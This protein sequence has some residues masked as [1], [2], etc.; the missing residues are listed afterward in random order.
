MRRARPD[1]GNRP[2]YLSLALLTAAV[3]LFAAAVLTWLR[4]PSDE[5]AVYGVVPAAL[6]I[7]AWGLAQALASGAYD[8]PHRHTSRRRRLRHH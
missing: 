1:P 8:L 7:V 5:A 3:L 4:T 2:G 6:L